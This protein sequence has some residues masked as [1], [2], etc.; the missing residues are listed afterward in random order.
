MTSHSKTYYNYKGRR[1]GGQQ[2]L[3]K[4][5]GG[6]LKACSLFMPYKVWWLIQIHRH[7][8]YYLHYDTPVAASL[9]LSPLMVQY[10]TPSSIVL[11]NLHPFLLC[12]LLWVAFTRSPDTLSL[13]CHSPCVHSTC[14]SDFKKEMQLSNLFMVTFR[15]Y[16]PAH[17]RDRTKY[18]DGRVRAK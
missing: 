2:V 9:P 16:E 10:L 11:G 4:V 7:L 13:S 5:T 1:W 3:W 14:D 8:V 12:F 18:I 15:K 17:C 6:L